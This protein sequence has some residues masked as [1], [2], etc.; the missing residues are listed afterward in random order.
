MHGEMK[1]EMKEMDHGKMGEGM[2]RDMKDAEHNKM[3][4]T[5]MAGTHHVMVTLTD[6]KSNRSMD[7]EKVTIEIF[8][9]SGK[10]G[11]VELASMMN[12]FGGGLTLGEKGTYSL[13]ILIEDAQ[14]TRTITV[15]YE[16]K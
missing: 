6:E 14:K 2:K 8:S 12:H 5:M 7:K 15:P 1:H 13:N 3:M 11:N 10:S 4:E 9:P 16:V